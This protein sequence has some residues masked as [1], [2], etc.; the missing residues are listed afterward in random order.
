M[1]YQ[2]CVKELQIAEIVIEEGRVSSVK[3]GRRLLQL[4]L[5]KGVT[6]EKTLKDWLNRRL[7]KFTDYANSKIMW[8]VKKD[9]FWLRQKGQNLNWK[10]LLCS[11]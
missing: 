5:P 3:L 11:A 4:F 10:D 1:V 2:L 6:C 8:V 9:N 7:K